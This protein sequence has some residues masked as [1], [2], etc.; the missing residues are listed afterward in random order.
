MIYDLYAG[1]PLTLYTIRPFQETDLTNDPQERA[2][3]EKFNLALSS[4]RV[5]IEHVFGR[6]KGRFPY[7]RNIYGELPSLHV[8]LDSIADLLYHRV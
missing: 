7:L 3:R 4:L 8:M 1:Y 2:L 5:T 6:L